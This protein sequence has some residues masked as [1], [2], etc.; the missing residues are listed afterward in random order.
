MT[1]DEFFD[2]RYRQQKKHRTMTLAQYHSWCHSGDLLSHPSNSTCFP[3][4][5]TITLGHASGIH[6]EVEDF[7]P[8]P[9][10]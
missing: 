3:G 7:E 2:W 10:K 9:R 6:G 4:G 8:P 5:L 1:S